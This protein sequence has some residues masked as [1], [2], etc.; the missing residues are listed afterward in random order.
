MSIAEKLTTIAENVPKVYDAGKNAGKAEESRAWWDC[1]TN[2]NTRTTYDYA[3]YQSNFNLLEGGFNP[4]YTLKPSYAGYIFRSARGVTKIKK[5]HF[6]W[7]NNASANYMCC[8][9]YDLEEVEEFE[10]GNNHMWTF[11]DCTKLKTIGK[12]TLRSG[13]TIKS[14]HP[15][16]NCNSLENIIFDGV[17]PN[18][19][20]FQWCSKLTVESMK[21]LISS[22]QDYSGTD[23]AFAYTISF[24]A[25]ALARL[26]AEGATSPNNNLWTDYVRDLGWNI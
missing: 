24:H 12:F 14:E 23:K 1:F 13:C 26:N 20:S 2:K 17:I 15:F 22:L 8:Y 3:F 10:I 19:V 7:S 11:S 6:D 5:E 9:C 16:A 4:P 25:D 18:S 21:S